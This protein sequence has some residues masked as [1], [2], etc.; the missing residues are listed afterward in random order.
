MRS[1]GRISYAQ[2]RSNPPNEALHVPLRR[3]SHLNCWMQGIRTGT[4][5]WTL[6]EELHAEEAH[7]RKTLSQDKTKICISSDLCGCKDSV[8]VWMPGECC[9]C[10]GLCTAAVLRGRGAPRGVSAPLRQW[11]CGK[12]I[13]WTNLSRRCSVLTRG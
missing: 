8:V 9:G 12:Y 6:S 11:L 10:W 2:P 13:S 4:G 7:Q 5:T 3:H 1:L